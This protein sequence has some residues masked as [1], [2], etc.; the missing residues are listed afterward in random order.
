L[1]FVDGKIVDELM[2]D[3]LGLELD[4]NL[5]EHSIQLF[6][7]CVIDGPHTLLQLETGVGGDDEGLR[8]RISSNNFFIKNNNALYFLR[9]LRQV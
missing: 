1:L 2:L 7:S 5:D 3:L 9:H 6:L 4:L 8:L